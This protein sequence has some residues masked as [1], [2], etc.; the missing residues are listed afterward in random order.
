M[1]VR[2]P[3]V[4]ER[5]KADEAVD[6]LY[7]SHGLR[8]IRL[9]FLMTGSAAVAEEIAQEGFIRL[10]R[11]WTRLDTPEAAYSYVRTTV[12]NLSRSFLRRS[13]LELRHRLMVAH[14]AFDVDLGDRVDML[15][16]LSALPVRQRACIVLR[17]YEDLTEV[18]TAHLLGVTVGTVKSQTFKALRRLERLVRDE[19][20]DA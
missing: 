16:A 4:G 10:L 12:V 3:A 5:S 2:E 8:V 1:V 13:R 18:D 11:A 20:N 15:N 14:H 9:A 17:Y 6:A 19:T 7:R